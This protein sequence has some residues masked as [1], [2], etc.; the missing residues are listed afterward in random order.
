MVLEG[1]AELID[2][3]NTGAEE[4]RVALRD[5]YRSAA[6]K[7]HPNWEEFDE[8]M[9]AERRAVVIVVPERVYGSAL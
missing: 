8:V 5:V 9:K 6:H 3:E 2:D 1:R 4:L 7:E